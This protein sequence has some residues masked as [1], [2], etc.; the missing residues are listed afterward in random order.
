MVSWCHTCTFRVWSESV[1][2]GVGILVNVP[3]SNH[4]QLIRIES[5][6]RFI[7][8]RVCVLENVCSGHPVSVEHRR[9]R[10]FYTGGGSRGGQPSQGVQA[11]A[12]CEIWWTI[13]NVFL[14]KNV[15]FNE[16]MGAEM[17][18][19]F[20]EHTN[21]TKTEHSMGLNTITPL[22]EYAS[23]VKH[24]WAQTVADSGVGSPRPHWPQDFFQ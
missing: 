5:T 23:D 7:R 3:V 1:Y 10:R 24:P 16:C 21:R 8:M 20:C 15:G 18:G 12:K 19:I 22:W 2:G 9:T 17:G 11:E 13:F 6:C 4:Q 14:Y